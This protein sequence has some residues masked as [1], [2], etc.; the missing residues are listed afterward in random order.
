MTNVSVIGSL[1][2]AS[3]LRNKFRSHRLSS[4]L[5]T[6]ASQEIL[7]TA[8]SLFLHLSPHLFFFWGGGILFNKVAFCSRGVIFCVASQNLNP[9]GSFILVS[10][11]CYLCLMVLSV[12]RKCMS[13]DKCFIGIISIFNHLFIVTS[14]VTTFM[15]KF[16]SFSVF[17][18]LA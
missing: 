12:N 18:L 8:A 13:S 15:H 5:Q 7:T 16:T 1:T 3:H 14:V 6:R 10:L 11:N 9:R 4:M 17:S 2:S